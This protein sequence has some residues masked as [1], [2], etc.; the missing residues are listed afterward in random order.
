MSKIVNTLAKHDISAV[1]VLDHFSRA[2]GV[3]SEADLLH[4]VEFLGQ[5]TETRFFEWG[6]K[7]VNHSKANADTA[8]ELMTSPAVTVQPGMSV[9]TAQ[10]LW[11]SDEVTVPAES[12]S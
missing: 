7:K 10:T 3:I 12:T 2:V 11:S 5:D 8:Q 9:I 4:K 1:P 6:T